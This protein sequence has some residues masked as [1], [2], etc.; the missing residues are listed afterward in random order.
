MTKINSYPFSRSLKSWNN[1]L[2]KLKAIKKESYWQDIALK[3]LA[4]VILKKTWT[5]LKPFRSLGLSCPNWSE[6]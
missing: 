3:M 1:I 6:R 2:S 4:T 5:L